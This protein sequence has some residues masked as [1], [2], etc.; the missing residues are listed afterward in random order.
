MEL[1]H[2]RYFVAVAERLHFGRAAA[3]LH[4]AQPSL[5]HQIQ[6]LEAELQTVLLE[7]TKRRVSLS[8]SGRVFLERAREILAN[9]DGAAVAARRTARGEFGRLRLGAA[10]WTD[11]SY[12]VPAVAR[13]LSRLPLV[14]VDLR[15][16]TG[17]E[18]VAA[19]REH[20]L[21]A[22]LLR[23]PVPEPFADNERL[24]IEP[25]VV[26]IA[27]S[28]GLASRRLV[29]LKSLANEPQ[30]MVQRDLAPNFHDSVFSLCRAAGFVPHVRA[31]AD[32]PDSM[33]SL[34]AARIGA[35]IV[36][37]WSSHLPTRG[38]VF[39]PLQGASL[40]F[41]TWIAWRRDA[42]SPLLR[43]FLASVRAVSSRPRWNKPG[44]DDAVSR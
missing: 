30:I 13:L 43:G 14:S 35:A 34:V 38:V 28:H 41:E 15:Q 12:V 20:R 42:V 23:R 11:P 2:L 24:M 16:I 44:A 18:Q 26:A 8:E 7:R 37:A 25:F 39:R 22:L 32:H 3:D 10:L 21:D 27:E 9:V 6:Q 19:L 1:R 4:I 5:S 29:P 36:P 31:E 33:L 17:L 40:R